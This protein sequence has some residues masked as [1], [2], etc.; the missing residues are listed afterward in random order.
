[1]RR[2]Q[3]LCVYAASAAALAPVALRWWHGP[4]RGVWC[5]VAV[6]GARVVLV[7]RGGG[8]SQQRRAP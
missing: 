2:A 7:V 4:C 3:L 6:C 1:V 5:G 8:A